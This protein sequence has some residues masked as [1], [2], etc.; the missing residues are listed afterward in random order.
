MFTNSSINII[1]KM[2]FL[3]FNNRNIVFTNEKF[4]YRYYTTTKALL[5][6]WQVKIINKKEFAKALLNKN[7]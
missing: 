3:T 4:I 5:T 1:L 2:I 6:I 7:I